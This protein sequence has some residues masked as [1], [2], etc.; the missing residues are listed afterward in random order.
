MKFAMSVLAVLALAG[1]LHAVH[2]TVPS[3]GSGALA[4]ELQDFMDLIPVDRVMA[5]LRGYAA[6]DKEFQTMMKLVD[7]KETVFYVKEMQVHP[8]A[9][10]LLNYMQNAGFDVY[11]VV[12]KL[13]AALGIKRIAPFASHKITGGFLGLMIDLANELPLKQLSNLKKSK[14]VKSPVFAAFVKEITSPT[15]HELYNLVHTNKHV[16]NIAQQ[17]KQAGIHSIPIKQ[18]YMHFIVARQILKLHP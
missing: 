5:V 16:V 1:S 7:S 9:K 8:A 10:K 6:Q 13:N 17:A 15:Y 18:Y 4:K 3:T 2:V 14:M 11:L 12:N